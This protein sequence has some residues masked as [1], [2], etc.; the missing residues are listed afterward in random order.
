MAE[1]PDPSPSPSPGPDPDPDLDLRLFSQAKLLAPARALTSSFAARV[2]F[3]EIQCGQISLAIDEAL[4]NVINHGY[5]RENEDGR[6]RVAIWKIDDHAP[7]MRIIVE[8]R[9]RQVDPETIQPRDLDDIRPGG[10][11]VHIIREI[12]DHVLYEKRDGGGMRLSMTKH[13]PASAPKG[14]TDGAP[15]RAACKA[16]GQ[17]D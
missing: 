17:H 2:G 9:A 6:I 5:G 1:P 15:R 11:G 13:V 12:M 14:T 4:C 10:L 8:D 16:E 7:G 3:D